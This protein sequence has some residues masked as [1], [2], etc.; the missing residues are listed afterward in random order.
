[1]MPAPQS[2]RNSRKKK[3]PSAASEA[4]TTST[5]ALICEEPNCARH[6]EPY[7]HIGGLRNHY[8][9]VIK[10]YNCTT[11]VSAAQRRNARAHNLRDVMHAV[12]K[13]DSGAENMVVNSRRPQPRRRRR[14]DDVDGSS[15]EDDPSDDIRSGDDEG[16]RDVSEDYD[17]DTAE[18]VDL[19]SS[20]EV[21]HV[22][23]QSTASTNTTNSRRAK[24]RKPV[25]ARGST[26]SS[27]TITTTTSR[28]RRTRTSERPSSSDP[29]PVQQIPSPART[30]L[31]QIQVLH[32][33]HQ[34]GG[35]RLICP[36]DYPSLSRLHLAILEGLPP[37]GGGGGWKI[38]TLEVKV[39]ETRI[40]ELSGEGTWKTVMSNILPK[41]DVGALGG[42]VLVDVVAR[43]NV[44]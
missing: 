28:N 9:N 1:M 35:L 43:V 12:E 38:D 19:D 34:V 27:T 6:T 24:L 36:S 29:R 41:E 44:C 25:A 40:I 17:Y 2:T 22:R 32:R 14:R 4:S 21:V 33:F 15:E 23:C 20:S 31:L 16:R 37:S 10:Y 18:E 42:M 8:V 5:P 39:S 7:V 13:L 30:P 11:G 26:A 3:T